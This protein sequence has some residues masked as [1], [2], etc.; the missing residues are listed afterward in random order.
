LDDIE[1]EYEVVIDEDGYEEMPEEVRFDEPVEKRI[2][3]VIIKPPIVAGPTPP[4][5]E[6]PSSEAPP[7]PPPTPD[8]VRSYSE[9]P[10]EVPLTVDQEEE[11]KR[12]AKRAGKIMTRAVFAWLVLTVFF[13]GLMAPWWKTTILAMA[14]FFLGI[15]LMVTLD[16]GVSFLNTFLIKPTIKSN[17]R[18]FVWMCA[19]TFCMLVVMVN[20]GMGGHPAWETNLNRH[21]AVFKKALEMQAERD[22][23]Y[24][25]GKGYGTD[26]ELNGGTPVD[27]ARDISFIESEP[28]DPVREK[29][30]YRLFSF[31]TLLVLTGFYGVFFAPRDE[32]WALINTL[33]GKAREKAE[34]D[35]IKA[36]AT[37]AAKMAPSVASATLGAP[38]SFMHNMGREMKYEVIFETLKKVGTG[39]KNAFVRR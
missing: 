30:H 10:D 12:R 13:I 31:L 16:F 33:W 9:P 5:P 15:S 7:P 2:Q 37:G 8:P 28:T 6:Q 20:G 18:W 26:A 4:T 11:D 39:L 27:P 23:N 32:G 35:P 38:G 17:N 25:D 29:F 36:V 22:K 1:A 34:G 21:D 24:A 19:L 14:T 3:A